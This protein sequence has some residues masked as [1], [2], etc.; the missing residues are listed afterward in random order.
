MKVSPST[1]NDYLRDVFGKKFS[2][3][4]SRGT[5]SIY[6][7]LRTLTKPGDEVVLPA[8]VCPSVLYAVLYAG[9]KPIL[10]D[11]RSD[12]F[13]MDLESLRE[14]VSDRTKVIIVVHLFGNACHIDEICKFAKKNG[15]IVI[16]DIA[17]SIG[18]LYNGQATGT[19]GDITILSFG[20][21]KIIDGG[22]GGAVLTNEPC[23]ADKLKMYS[24]F[25]DKPSKFD[26]IYELYRKL[27]YSAIELE[28]FSPS[29][30]YKLLKEFPEAFRDLFLFEI[31]SLDFERIS[32]QFTNMEQMKCERQ[33]NAL[34]YRE[35]LVHPLIFHPPF[36]RSANIYRYSLL[37]ASK[38]LRDK[39][40]DSLR[41]SGFHASTLYP[42]LHLFIYP[43]KP[44]G[45]DQVSNVSERIVN[46][47]VEPGL[48]QDYVE[49]SSS[50]ILQVLNSLK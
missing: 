24:H 42:S 44:K 14:V 20:E 41:L 15:I 1:L 29:S 22:G 40:V 30:S 17:Q 47:W 36:D 19:L 3:F 37:L 10:C 11:I 45:L 6:A 34:K 27:Y 32:Q 43:D 25:P 2:F 9:A 28:S 7:A 39:V 8:M 38:F 21:H 50:L 12:D 13:T 35:L 4:T 18:T 5:S 16:E 48:R 46:L 26:S 33:R 31:P 49:S 23:I